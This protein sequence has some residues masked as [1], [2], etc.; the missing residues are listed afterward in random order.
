MTTL[1]HPAR[2][3]L[4]AVALAGVFAAASPGASA[5]DTWFARLPAAAGAMPELALGTGNR[6]PKQ[7][8]AVAAEY[9]ARQGCRSAADAPA[10]ALQ[11]LGLTDTA[12]RLRAPTSAAGSSCWAQLQ[13]FEIELAPALV[14]LYLDEVRASPALRAQWAQLQ[15]RGLPWRERYTKHAR[16]LLGALDQASGGVA[17]VPADSRADGRAERRTGVRDDASGES[18]GER[19]PEPGARFSAVS[20]TVAA[21]AAWPVAARSAEPEPD[22]D[23]DIRLEAP[24][25]TPRVGDTLQFQVLSRGLPLPGLNLELRSE[26]SPL[27]IWRQTDAEGRVRL[28]AALPGQW[29]LRGT[30]IQPAA[31]AGRWESRFVTLAFEVLPAAG[32]RK[33]AP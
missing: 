24:R 7:E 10:V 1:L 3:A 25:S 32:A 15:A 6:Y 21:V 2:R 14:A 5:H 28:P 4:A 16:V 9:L 13:P 17:D 23:L 22:M 33:A 11:P 8:F 31:D 30:E 29:L 26:L 20:D 27:G 18:H 12:L 19:R